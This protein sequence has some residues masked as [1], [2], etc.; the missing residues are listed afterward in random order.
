MAGSLGAQQRVPA[1]NAFEGEQ[2]RALDAI[3]RGSGPAPSDE[4][5]AS[6]GYAGPLELSGVQHRAPQGSELLAWA[7]RQAPDT[8]AAG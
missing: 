5:V 3:G 7:P 2:G 1:T 6:R 8:V 4:G